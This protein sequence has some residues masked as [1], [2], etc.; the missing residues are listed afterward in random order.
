MIQN[1]ESVIKDIYEHMISCCPNGTPYKKMYIG[2]TADATDRLF[3][4]HS[5]DREKDVWIFRTASSDVVAREIE[6]HFI[7]LGF[8][9]G[10]GGGDEKSKMVYCFLQN[11]HT[12]R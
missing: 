2:I 6:Q 5:V 9:G 8:D 7:D 3:K 4:E 12:R 1:K 10:T 11:N